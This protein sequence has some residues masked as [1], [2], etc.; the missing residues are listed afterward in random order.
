MP[1]SISGNAASV[2]AQLRLS[3]TQEMIDRSMAKLA[4]GLRIADASDDPAGLGISTQFDTQ[5][6]SYQQ[7]ARNTNASISMLQT[8][9]GALGQMHGALQRM[10]ELAV[11][12]SNGTLSTA[13]RS[14][15]QTEIAQLQTEIT[16]ISAS[17]KFGNLQ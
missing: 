2:D 10:R 16:R 12:S 9:D 15:N 1:L 13:D 5:V 3:R 6:R 4:S 7:A 8:V 11:Q 17:T 14:N